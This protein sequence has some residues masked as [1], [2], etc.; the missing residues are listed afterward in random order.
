[1][2]ILDTPPWL[3]STIRGSLHNT[4]SK[5]CES[6]HIARA[7]IITSKRARHHKQDGSRT[8]TSTD[9]CQTTCRSCTCMMNTWAMAQEVLGASHD[10]DVWVTL[11][12]AIPLGCLSIGYPIFQHT[13]NWWITLALAF[14]LSED[15]L[16]VGFA[17]FICCICAIMRSM[18]EARACV[19]I[20]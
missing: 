4:Y 13:I 17:S 2:S 16:S 8:R 1:M 15:C 12:L 10:K 19:A 7:N 14:P 3:Y 11:A 9:Y 5:H 18:H 20:L 6:K